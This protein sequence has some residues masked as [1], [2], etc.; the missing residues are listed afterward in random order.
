MNHVGDEK[1]LVTYGRSFAGLLLMLLISCGG[2]AGRNT[3][4]DLTGTWGGAHIGIMVGEKSATL[5][6]DCAHGTISEPLSPDENGKFEVVGVHIRE[7]GGPIL[8]GD[9]P[10]EHPA[11]YKGFIKGNEMTLTVT[12]T[13]SGEEVGTFSLTRG[14]P[15]QVQKCYD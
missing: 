3:L 6:Y 13:D 9:I 5:D 12:L 15:P 2:C 1:P 8:L 11:S 10:D 7:H 4:T 14:S